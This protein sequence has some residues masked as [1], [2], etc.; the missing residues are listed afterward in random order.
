MGKKP[1]ADWFAKFKDSKI[2]ARIRQRINRLEEGNYGDYKSV[3]D[4]VYELRLFF[5]S[6]YRI[7]FAEVGDTVV[8]LLC[9]GDKSSQSKD[10]EKA[11]EYWKEFKND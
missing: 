11:K 2:K 7:Y 3:G 8:L 10:I 4:G 5:G 1:F 6:G 9:A